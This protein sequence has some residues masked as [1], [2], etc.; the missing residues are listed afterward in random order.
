MTLQPLTPSFL[1]VGAID[2]VATVESPLLVTAVASTL[3]ISRAVLQRHKT[4]EL[5]DHSMQ[6]FQKLCRTIRKMS[7]SIQ[8]WE[9][10]WLVP[11]TATPMHM[12]YN[13][14]WFNDIFWVLETISPEVNAD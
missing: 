2:E 14:I 12:R 7:I 11:T 1:S 5:P 3:R 10:V 13:L 8:C 4:S 9:R 6:T